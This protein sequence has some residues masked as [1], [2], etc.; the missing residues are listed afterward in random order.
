MRQRNTS[1]LELTSVAQSKAWYSACAHL[2][3]GATQR[4]R[5]STR[6]PGSARPLAERLAEEGER[7]GASKVRQGKPAIFLLC[8]A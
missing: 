2:Y 1:Y 8:L 4:Q 6:N 3:G 5:V 7:E